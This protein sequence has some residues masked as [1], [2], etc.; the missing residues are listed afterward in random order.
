MGNRTST[1]SELETEEEVCEEAACSCV[2]L[3]DEFVRN[4]G[5]K[6]SS[7]LGW[8]EKDGVEG[9]TNQTE[10]VELDDEIEDGVVVH[11][12]CNDW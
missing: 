3:Q 4:F 6:A 2:F 11:V 1:T 10:A 7:P 9:L 5:Y 8:I 12:D